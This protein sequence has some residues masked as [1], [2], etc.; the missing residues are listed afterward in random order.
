MVLSYVMVSEGQGAAVC[1]KR[2]LTLYV[3]SNSLEQSLYEHNNAC[4]R[5]DSILTRWAFKAYIK[6]ENPWFVPRGLAFNGSDEPGAPGG[7][8]L[9][10]FY[11]SLPCGDRK[12]FDALAQQYIEIWDESCGAEV[13]STNRYD[14]T[15][16]ESTVVALRNLDRHQVVS[17]FQ[18]TLVRLVRYRIHEFDGYMST[19][20]SSRRGVEYL[21]LGPARFIN[22][23]CDPNAKIDI[24][25]GSLVV[26]VRMIKGLA[27]GQAITVSYSSDFFGTDNMG[28]ACASCESQVRGAWRYGLDKADKTPLSFRTRARLNANP[29]I[30]WMQMRDDETRGAGT[31]TARERM[32]RFERIPG[33]YLDAAKVLPSAPA[34]ALCNI[35]GLYRIVAT[36]QSCFRCQ[37]HGR[38]YRTPWPSRT[39]VD[40]GNPIREWDGF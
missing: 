19:I 34:L 35:C 27:A 23:D 39:R 2:L 8:S 7:T 3:V 29:P 40:L 28:C 18:G 31:I 25:P 9:E 12:D 33:D 5:F 38:I 10:E 30:M 13:T 15:T 20:R 4:M 16:Q 36:E 11:F 21:L 37:R 24:I 22:H 26:Q 17:K 6:I 14:I 32:A 1:T